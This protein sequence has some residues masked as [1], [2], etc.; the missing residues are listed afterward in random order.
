MF[1]QVSPP[2]RAI[3]SQSLNT[4]VFC[5]PFVFM[6]LRIHPSRLSPRIDFYFHDF[7]ALTNPLIG[8]SFVFTSI[9]NPGGV[10]PTIVPDSRNSRRQMCQAFYF[11]TVANSL[12]SQRKSSALESTT[13]KLFWQN[14]RGGGLASVGSS[15]HAVCRPAASKSGSQLGK[16]PPAWLGAIIPVCIARSGGQLLPHTMF[17][18]CPPAAASPG[19]NTCLSALIGSRKEKQMLLPQMA[20]AIC[21]RCILRGKASSRKRCS[22]SPSASGWSPS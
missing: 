5:S 10:S 11:H 3:D 13:S 19:G 9:Q 17:G 18:I 20:I 15:A 6:S 16:L 21:R 1:P 7:H 12:S 14:T 22:S 8:N 4:S 2:C